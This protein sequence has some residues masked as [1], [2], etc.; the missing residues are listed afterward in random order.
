MQLSYE[1][2]IPSAEL[3]LRVMTQDL[4]LPSITLSA[5]PQTS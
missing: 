4:I 3:Q 1:D 5:R 2:N